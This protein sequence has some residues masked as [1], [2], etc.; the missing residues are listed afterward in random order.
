MT[1]R[2]RQIG[3]IAGWAGEVVPLSADRLPP[4]LRTPYQPK[5]DLVMDTTKV[6]SELGFGEPV[7]YEEGLRRTIAWE[8]ATLRETGDPGAAEYAAEDAALSGAPS[9]TA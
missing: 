1:Q 3:D 5:Q 4:H 2:I 8:R 7:S 6:R 9:G